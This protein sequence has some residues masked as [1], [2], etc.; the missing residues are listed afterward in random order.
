MIV[1]Q[2][3]VEEVNSLVTNESLILGVDKTV[4]SLLLEA[5]EDFIVLGIKL[6]LVLVQVVEQIVCTKDLG[7]FDKLIRVAVS[8]EK[9]LFSK[10]HGCEHSTKTPHVQTIVILLEIY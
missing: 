2:Q 10:Y 6:D 3:F 7:D 5:A 4:P 1:S 9:R 8:V